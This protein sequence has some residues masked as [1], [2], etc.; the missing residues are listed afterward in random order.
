MHDEGNGE[1]DD[2]LVVA[3]EMRSRYGSVPLLL[4]GFSFGAYVNASGEAAPGSR[5][6]GR[7]AAIGSPRCRA[8]PPEPVTEGTLV[9]HGESDDVVPLPDVLASGASTAVAGGSVAGCR[10]LLSRQPG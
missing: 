9:I 5:N 6:A 4:A 10:S 2:W 1:T 3:N 8:F 7:A